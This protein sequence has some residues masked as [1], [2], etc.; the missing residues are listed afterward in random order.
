MNPAEQRWPVLAAIALSAGVGGVVYAQ[1]ADTATE[2]AEPEQAEQAASNGLELNIPDLLPG[3]YNT[4]F[5]V[6]N[7]TMG[8]VLPTKWGGNTDRGFTMPPRTEQVCYTGEQLQ[9]ASEFLPGNIAADDNCRVVS[10]TLEG[11]HGEGEIA[12]VNQNMRVIIRYVGNFT[13]TSAQ[14]SFTGQMRSKAQSGNATFKF[15]VGMERIA[16]TCTEDIEAEPGDSA[17]TIA[18][19]A[20]KAI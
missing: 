13:E 15:D 14:I 6:R 16:E 10:S 8:M 7:M 17:S 5:T 11:T 12:C 18:E 20:R 1:A 19:E 2:A 9:R 4:T 3:Y